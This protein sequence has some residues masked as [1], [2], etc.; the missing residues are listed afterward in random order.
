MK[1]TQWKEGVVYQIYPRSFLDTNRDGI[2]DLQGII[3]KLDYIKEL[4]ATIIWICPVFESPNYDNGYD[5][6]DY[7][8][9]MPE[10]G[11]MQDFDLLLSEAH[12]RGLRLIIDMVVNHTSSQHPWFLESK[13]STDNPYREYYIWREG[14]DGSPPNNWGACFGGSTWEKDETTDSYYFHFF[15][16][17]QPD[18]NWDNPAV[19]KDIYDIMKWWLD[20]GVDGF[21]MDAITYISKCPTMP[22]GEITESGYGYPRPFVA[23]GPHLHEYLKE[24]N[25]TVLSHYDIMTVG[26]TSESG[27]EDAK[28]FAGEDSG[29]FNMILHFEHIC[30][31]GGDTFKWTKRKIDLIEMKDLFTKWQDGIAGKAWIGLYWNN[32]DQPRALARLGDEDTFREKSAKMIA[33]NT[34]LMQGTPFIYQG[35]ELGMTNATFNDVSEL[36]DPESINAYHKYTQSGLYSTQE[37]L[38]ILSLRARDNARTPMQWDTTQYAGFSNTEPW[39]KVNQNYK[40]INAAEQISRKDSVF[41]YYKQL[42]SLRKQYEVIVYGSYELLDRDNPQVYAYTRELDGEKILVVCNFTSRTAFSEIPLEFKTENRTVLIGNDPD[43]KY[44]ETAELSPYEAI[45]LLR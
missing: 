6:S 8:K 22:D 5:I 27:I 31:D 44:L 25:R 41:N 43:S 45:V 24:M 12:K 4:G 18:L 33:T 2:G 32:H 13:K 19:R 21:R 39:I 30:L 28:L 14:K 36:R 38:E 10:F 23:N 35:E 11:T 3:Q 17:Q 34:Q 15:L 16:P 20:K 37:M 9:I 29:E 40:E 7:K 26:E 42:N 1:K